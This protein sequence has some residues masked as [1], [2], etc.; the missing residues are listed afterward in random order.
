VLLAEDNEINQQ[1]A[2]ELLEGAGVTVDV[3][4]TGREVLERL[5]HA[6]RGY[7]AVLMDLQMPDMDGLEATRRLR[8]DVRFAELPVIAM[9]AHAMVE[10]RERCLAAGMVDHIAKPIEPQ[11]MFR[12]LAHW[13]K[14]RR[15]ETATPR[16]GA[17]A[18][19]EL[20]RIEGVD[21]VTG[22][23]RVGGNRNL[24]LRLLRRFAEG[25]AG[26]ARRVR[27][28]LV[29]GDRATAE[30]E[31]HTVKGVAANL[32]LA[33][34]SDLAAALEHAV[35]GAAGEER[36]LAEFEPALVRAVTA[37]AALP[38]ADDGA[39]SAAV[40][41]A[42]AAGPELAQLARLLEAGDGEAVDYLAGRAAALRAAFRDGEFVAIERAVES[43]EFDAAL[44][45]LRV[46]A[47]RA[48]IDLQEPS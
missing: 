33:G 35:H 3:A 29:A 28:A 41:V 46:A 7:D 44:A 20:P 8:A 18:A 26:A 11:A 4:G 17:G 34:L 13:V 9:T 24:Y 23:R 1:I 12:T 36:A 38:A 14:G 6:P 15:A 5:E 19:G 45:H 2:V 43:F 21:V 40:V 10:E 16:S 39:T 42:P 48:G 22:L 25:Q 27:Q 30:R 31:A 32:G 37:L 47:A